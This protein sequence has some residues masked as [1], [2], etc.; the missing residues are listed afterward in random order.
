MEKAYPIRT[1]RYL[2][3][4]FVILMSEFSY[5]QE[6][7][8]Q[9]KVSETYDIL[10]A[11]KINDILQDEQGFFWI[12]AKPGISRFDGH[13]I[14]S[15][16]LEVKDS[17]GNNDFKT[18]DIT[19]VAMAKNGDVWMCAKFGEFARFDRKRNKLI[20]VDIGNGKRWE[21][22][23]KIL[24]EEEAIDTL[25][26]L[27]NAD[28]IV[29]NFF[30]DKI[31]VDSRYNIWMNLTSN[32][33]CKVVLDTGSFDQEKIKVKDF[34]WFH[35]LSTGLPEHF[36]AVEFFEDNTGKMWIPSTMGL[37]E[38]DPDTGAH[39]LHQVTNS[40]DSTFLN[41]YVYGNSIVGD[42]ML[43]LGSHGRGLVTFN[44]RTKE[45]ESFPF[46]TYLEDELKGHTE[47]ELERIHKMWNIT[48]CSI[49]E[50]TTGKLWVNGVIFGPERHY[51]FLFDIKTKEF[52]R[53][54]VNY[55]DNKKVPNNLFGRKMVQDE[56]N[57]FWIS[58]SLIN[59]PSAGTALL[60]MEQSNKSFDYLGPGELNN[61]NAGEG[62]IV[63]PDSLGNL[64]TAN[65]N[66]LI[67][68]DLKNGNKVMYYPYNGKDYQTLYPGKPVPA[69]FFGFGD[70]KIDKQGKLWIGTNYGLYSMDPGTGQWEIDSV[71]HEYKKNED[72][73]LACNS[74]SLTNDGK[75]WLSY[76]KKIIYYD[77]KTK[78][79][80]AYNYPAFRY[81]HTSALVWKVLWESDER[82]WFGFFVGGPMLSFNPKEI[83]NPLNPDLS[84][85]KEYNYSQAN[86]MLIDS[87]GRL[88][89]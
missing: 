76:Y 33:F 37:L 39:E 64:W 25:D 16:Q 5:S 66:G 72:I 57:N 26:I 32:S 73:Q 75:L 23:R 30:K 28:S 9:V 87:R 47:E 78:D 54:K 84:K 48:D 22:Y 31:F 35:H 50:K 58:K 61:L 29:G 74:I 63:C 70:I 12:P 88:W 27:H 3:A 68:I 20:T 83:K 60:K 1:L 52:E 56:S 36:R 15:F 71:L 24:L 67:Y 55:E 85:F 82:V 69:D 2:L 6:K 43:Y 10:P 80:T 11:Q 7:I 13:G 89:A 49:L 45:M 53:V 18:A 86:P 8:Y 17:L 81:N 65:K 38:L 41:G 42:S 40:P 14:E 4:L 79:F 51:S 34:Q 19:S 21:N 46:T 44:L 62:N 77:P 59:E